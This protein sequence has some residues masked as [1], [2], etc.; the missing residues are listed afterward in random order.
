M[1]VRFLPCSDGLI[2]ELAIDKIEPPRRYVN[3]IR[4]STQIVH[5]RLGRD[6]LSTTAAVRDVEEFLPNETGA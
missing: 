3:G 2:S 5:Y 6:S 1:T 4:S